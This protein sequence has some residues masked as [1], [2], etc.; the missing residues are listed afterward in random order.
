MSAGDRIRL[1]GLQEIADINTTVN[2]PTTGLVNKVSDL[3]D[4][5]VYTL[6]LPY[7]STKTY[8]KG[9]PILRD[10]Q[11]LI[12][13]QDGVT[14]TFDENKWD[15]VKGRAT[16][17]PIVIA[18][19]GTG[20]T[21][22]QVVD[23]VLQVQ[24]T[25]GTDT[26]LATFDPASGRWNLPSSGA[27]A[28]AA[29]KDALVKDDVQVTSDKVLFDP[30]ERRL[31]RVQDAPETPA[32][33][34]DGDVTYYEDVPLNRNNI[35]MVAGRPRLKS[36]P[37]EDTASD[38]DMMTVSDF[39][40]LITGMT[41]VRNSGTVDVS[42]SG[43]TITNSI[44]TGATATRVGVGRVTLGGL[45]ELSLTKSILILESLSDGDNLMNY[46][47][48]TTTDVRIETRDAP[49][50]TDQDQDFR[51]FWLEIL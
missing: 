1:F 30:T 18:D 46:R 7:V 16:T 2:D 28:D 43:A 49:N 11:L 23:G 36:S 12:A 32:S 34:A 42:S 39:K 13:N 38:D 31:Q 45:T 6:T 50:F 24:A 21:T 40:S 35:G 44:G 26:S 27:I 47:D 20:Q 4:N 51:F 9:Y 48:K 3:K 29:G 19:S 37:S 33:L 22:V 14:G 5:P 8:Q 10:S 41:V 25:N 17:D 15:S